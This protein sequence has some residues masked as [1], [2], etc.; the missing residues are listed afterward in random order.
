[1]TTS[2]YFLFV[3]ISCS[4]LQAQQ[5]STEKQWSKNGIRFE[6]NQACSNHRLLRDW[7]YIEWLFQNIYF[8]LSLNELNKR[9]ASAC[10]YWN[11]KSLIFTSDPTRFQ[12]KTEI[13]FW[14]IKYDS[15]KN[16]DYLPSYPMINFCIRT[17][18]QYH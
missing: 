3:R 11:P 1:M 4:H 17:L 6:I 8:F 7:F 15:G 14:G 18:I 10:G 5:K 12:S 16:N 2:C 13:R 9:R